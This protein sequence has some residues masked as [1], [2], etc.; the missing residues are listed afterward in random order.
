MDHA[1]EVLAASG[2]AV[3][4]G[5]P[6][7]GFDGRMASGSHFVRSVANPCHGRRGLILGL[8]REVLGEQLGQIAV[9]GE[10]AGLGL[11]REFIG[12]GDGDLHG[13]EGSKWG[14]RMP[15]IKEAMGGSGKRNS[16]FPRE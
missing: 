3:L 15:P 13:L 8:G 14:G 2:E 12:D 9:E 4:F 11:G 1:L 7:H 6:E 16:R 5:E 10:A